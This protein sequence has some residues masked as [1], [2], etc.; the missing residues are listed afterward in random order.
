MHPATCGEWEYKDY[1][2]QNELDK[3]CIDALNAVFASPQILNSHIADTRPVH[4]K[5]FDE[6]TPVDQSYLAG[7]YRGEN[8]SC[9]KFRPVFIA[10]YSGTDSNQVSSEMAEFHET[11]ESVMQTLEL[12]FA[13]LQTVSQKK[14][15]EKAT[16]YIYQLSEFAAAIYVSFLVIHP[17][18]NGNGH[19]ARW[20]V[21]MMLIRAKRHP[22]TW[23]LNTRPPTD[24]LIRLY[25]SHDKQPL[26][27]YIIKAIRGH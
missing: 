18:A 12:K 26:I 24:E 19:L 20:I 14:K 27:R 13:E 5:W 25:R 15:H 17:Y 2:K 7:N 23:P 3:R 6:L 4:A 8:Y 21:W 22:K 16:A 10:G 11:L 9:L 1:P